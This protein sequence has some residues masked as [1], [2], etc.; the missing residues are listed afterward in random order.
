MRTLAFAALCLL[1][2][3]LPTP[4][5]A[6]LWSRVPAGLPA[7]SLGP[8]LRALESSPDHALAAEAARALGQFHHARGEYRA[9]AEAFG[10]AAARLEGYA[11]AEAR[12][13]QGLACLGARED[14]R[15]RAAFEEVLRTSLPLRP[16]AQLGLAEA[17]LLAG[18]PARALDVLQRLLDGP[19]GEAEPAALERY[20]ELCD[21]AHRTSDA[22]AARDRLR[23]RW[24]RSFEAARLAAAAPEARP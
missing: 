13:H 2:L 10:R 8:V 12:Y 20:A 16:L 11:R 4:A 3:A 7:D 22:A 19:A 14:G 18:E 6:Q 24:P 5:A 17:H 21:R 15:A 1:T 9:A 23:R